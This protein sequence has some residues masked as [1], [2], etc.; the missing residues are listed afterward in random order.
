VSTTIT[1]TGVS[2]KTRDERKELLATAVANEIRQGWRVESQ[3]DYQAVIVKGNRPNH[4]LH[5]LLTLF[6]L[7]L[8]GMFGSQSSPSAA[9]SVASSG[10]TSAAG[11]TSCVSRSRPQ[12]ELFMSS[13]SVVP[14][15]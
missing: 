14:P 12:N 13:A 8:W 2:T 6:T 3:S 7:G 5:L 9:R 15:M 1:E 10:S 4:L 11:Q